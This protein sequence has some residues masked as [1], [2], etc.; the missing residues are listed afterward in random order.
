MKITIDV[1][2]EPEELR[3]LLGLPDA[4]K[5]WAAIY[6][7]V[8]EGDSEMALEMIKNFVGES[9]KANEYLGR[10]A[11]GLKFMQSMRK[12]SEK[13]SKKTSG[14]RKKTSRKKTS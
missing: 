13:P 4:N 14:T 1:D 2:V 10:F 3:R 5:F 7:R 8:E 12:T 6:K 9:F 11:D